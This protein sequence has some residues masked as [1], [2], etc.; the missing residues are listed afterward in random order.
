M[1][2]GAEESGRRQRRR[3]VTKTRWRC[4]P[5]TLSCATA[6]AA[7]EAILSESHRWHCLY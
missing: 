3:T 6:R 4:A 5:T 7:S 2:T 1:I